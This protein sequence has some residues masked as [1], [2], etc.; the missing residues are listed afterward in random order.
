[1]SSPFPEIAPDFTQP[2][3]LLR[4]CHDKILHHCELLEQLLTE[5]NGDKI[6]MATMTTAQKIYKYFHK[7][8]PEHHQDEEQ[9]LFVSLARQSL[10]LADRVH[11]CKKEHQQ[12][13]ALW[14]QIGPQIQRP[15]LIKEW[16]P[17]LAQC[18]E[19]IQ[20]Q[21][22]HVAYENEE[23]LDMAQHIFGQRELEKMGRAMAERRGILV[24]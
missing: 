12:L 10:K 17:F 8:A 1:M 16:Q 15:N 22:E 11:R 4:T 14:A 7:S 21:R 23:L 5:L 6:D 20:V 13:E 24:R 3:A 19:F 2:L 18:R 9:Q